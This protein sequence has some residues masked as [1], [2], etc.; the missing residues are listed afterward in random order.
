M[1]IVPTPTSP[2]HSHTIPRCARGPKSTVSSDSRSRRPIQ[3]TVLAYEN[4]ESALLLLLSGT[5]PVQFRGATYRFPVAI[6]IP[7]AY[8]HASPMVYVM[9]TSDQLVRPGQHVSSDGRVYHPYLAQWAQY[10]DVSLAKLL[11]LRSR[12]WR[13]N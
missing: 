1:L 6:W 7:H 5:L 8:P 13:A 3:L 2:T 11:V 10:W 9:P 12:T 4:G